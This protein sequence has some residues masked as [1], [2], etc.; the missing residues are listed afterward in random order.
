MDDRGT[1]AVLALVQSLGMFAQIC[2]IFGPLCIMCFSS[3]CS[4]VPVLS[5]AL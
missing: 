1:N 4:L 5:C 2:G 3:L